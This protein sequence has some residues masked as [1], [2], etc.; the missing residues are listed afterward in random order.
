M[1]GILKKVMCEPGHLRKTAWRSGEQ[2]I[3]ALPWGQIQSPSSTRD[4][5]EGSERP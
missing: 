1:G 4:E 2:E 3:L 5:E